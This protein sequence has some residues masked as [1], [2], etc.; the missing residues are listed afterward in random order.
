MRVLTA[1]ASSF[2]ASQVPTQSLAARALR[3]AATVSHFSM[4]IIYASIAI[5]ALGGFGVVV[6][7][8][9]ALTVAPISS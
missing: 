2:G 8:E 7:Q 9:C 5:L 6:L 4:M 3:T 1:F